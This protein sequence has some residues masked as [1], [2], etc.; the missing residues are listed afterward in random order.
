MTHSSEDLAVAARSAS[1]SFP[2]DVVGDLVRLHAAPAP[3]SDLSSPE[4]RVTL[5]NGDLLAG[6]V[7]EF[8]VVERHLKHPLDKAQFI[9]TRTGNIVSRRSV[10]HGS[11]K[12]LIG[13]KVCRLFSFFFMLF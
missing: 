13:G 12:I 11:Q 4:F 2:V 7:L 9:K 6:P 3:L 1:D 10:L 5:L 8:D